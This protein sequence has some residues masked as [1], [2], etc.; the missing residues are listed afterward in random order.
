M[1]SASWATST[2]R[3]KPRNPAEP[4]MLCAARKISFRRS[5]SSGFFSSA[6][7]RWSSPS[8]TSCDSTRKSW[9]I[10]FISSFMDSSV[11]RSHAP[12]GRFGQ[13]AGP[14][15]SLQGF[16]VSVVDDRYPYAALRENLLQLFFDGLGGKGLDDVIAHPGLDR[17][18]EIALMRFSRHHKDR[19]MFECG[20][21]LDVFQEL[22]SGHD[23]H[24]PVR[25]DQVKLPCLQPVERVSSV[26]RLFN[27]GKAQL[28]KNVFDDSPHG[29]H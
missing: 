7:K 18:D 20:V 17:L 5:V 26:L 13:D 21:R 4:F 9:T 22:D 19:N 25:Y 27:I 11:I 16:F 24:V 14:R 29:G 23:R 2:S 3:L 1:L 28:L 15:Q 6:I 8:S 10:S 12:F